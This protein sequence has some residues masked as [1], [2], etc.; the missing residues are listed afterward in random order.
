MS[1]SNRVALRYIPEVTYGTTPTNGVWQ[2]LRFEGE[3]FTA[4]PDVTVSNEIRS[5]RHISDQLQT[6][7]TVGGGFNF[8]LS[9]N[10]YDDLIESALAGTWTA[11]VLKVGTVDSS[12]SIEKEFEDITA[13][14][15]YTGIS[16]TGMRVGQMSLSLAY[17]AIATG[18]FTFAGNGSDTP[19]A[20][21]VGTGSVTA[22]TST[23]IL[24]ASSDVN[25]VKINGATTDICITSMVLD[26]NNNLRPITCIGSVAPTNQSKGSAGVTGT[27]EL[28]LDS[29]SFVM[30]KNV[31]TQTE[32]SLEYT[33]TD[34]T[35]SY[36]FFLPKVKLSGDAPMSSGKDQ[37]VMLSFSYTALYDA[38]EDTS[39]VITRVDA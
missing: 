21:L 16:F 24:N 23:P 15:T 30:Y 10:S 35:N 14:S 39:L 17:G 5:D 9:P 8:E 37:D 26:I 20:S 4:T 38:T 28:Y 1:E 6:G 36:K 29:N 19:T 27:V 12:Y 32:I 7:L 25:S 11:D 2:A 13:A 22:A 34:G 31:L 3:S 18:T 33:I